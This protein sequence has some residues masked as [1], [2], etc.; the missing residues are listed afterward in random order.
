MVTHNDAIKHMADRVI[1]LRDGLIRN[2]E[3]NTHKQT[4]EELEW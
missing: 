3:L 1:K 4:A 2:N